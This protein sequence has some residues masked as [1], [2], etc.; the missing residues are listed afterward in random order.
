MASHLVGTLSHSL[1]PLGQ[2]LHGHVATDLSRLAEVA[3]FSSELLAD[4]TEPAEIS[5]GLPV[6]VVVISVQPLGIIAKK[7]QP[8]V[9]GSQSGGPCKKLGGHIEVSALQIAHGSGP[10]SLDYAFF[11]HRGEQLLELFLP[12]YLDKELPVS[13]E[14]ADQQVVLRVSSHQIDQLIESIVKKASDIGDAFFNSLLCPQNDFL[15]SSEKPLPIRSFFW[16]NTKIAGSVHFDL[17]EVLSKFHGLVE[18]GTNSKVEQPFFI[19]AL[20]VVVMSKKGVA[21]RLETIQDTVTLVIDECLHM[22]ESQCSPSIAVLY[23][24]MD[25]GCLEQVADNFNDLLLSPMV[26]CGPV[27]YTHIQKI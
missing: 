11:K 2:T 16:L 5:E 25:H 24:P 3:A 22:S 6:V 8:F 14:K 13:E 1:I 20:P 15:K 21:V 4:P 9:I 12:I 7:L 18:Y 10:M 23:S 27:V 17:I 19:L 26:L